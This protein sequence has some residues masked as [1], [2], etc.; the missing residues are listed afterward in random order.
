MLQTRNKMSN[1]RDILIGKHSIRLLTIF[2]LSG[3]SALIYQV[4]WQRLLCGAVGVDIESV[5]VIV[6]TFMLGLG[7]GALWGGQ[8]A[9]RFRYHV[10][11]LFALCEFGIGLFGIVSPALIPFVGEFF[12]S[13]G[14]LVIAVANFILILIP[15]SFMGATLPMLV[16]YSV[17][18]DSS[19]GASIGTLYFVNTLGASI[20]AFAAGI[21]LFNFITI[22]QAIYLAASGN[23]IVA[24]VAYLSAG[25]GS[26][27]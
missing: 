25:R 17:R 16:A 11:V 22:T 12:I 19:V 18:R 6:S 21:V 13:Y 5:T 24:L 7:C 9:D 4:W 1:Q 15:A 14:L 3:A 8:A 10:I 23:L 27:E 20:G 26:E 2:F